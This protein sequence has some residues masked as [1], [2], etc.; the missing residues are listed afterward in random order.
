MREAVE[1]FRK[2]IQLAP[3]DIE[4]SHPLKITTSAG[5]ASID[6]ASVASKTEQDLYR[7][8]DALLYLAKNSGRNN[9]KAQGDI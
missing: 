8:A 7:S 9:V 1:N 5:V 3:I 2:E 6:S 4:A